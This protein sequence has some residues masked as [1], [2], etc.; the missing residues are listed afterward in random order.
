M[1]DIR[2]EM[3]KNPKKDMDNPLFLVGGEGYFYSP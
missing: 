3:G 1:R 2:G